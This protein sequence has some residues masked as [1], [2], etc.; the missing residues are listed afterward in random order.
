VRPVRARAF[1]LA[2]LAAAAYVLACVVLVIVGLSDRPGRA[3]IAIVPGTRVTAD[4]R[5]LPRL[6]ARCR[7][8]LEVWRTGYARLIFVSGTMGSGGQNQAGVMKRWLVE[9]GVPDSV[10]VTDSLGANSWLSAR[11]ARRWLDAHG[12]HSAMIV[13][14]G[15]HVPRMRLACARHGI[16]PLYWTHARY[17]EPLDLYSIAREIPGLAYYALRPRDRD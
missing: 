10:V 5:P 17:F 9:H 2:A 1:R 12:L 16:A 11:D 6:V 4:G 3:D 14:Q 8:A 15:F 7:R 13:T